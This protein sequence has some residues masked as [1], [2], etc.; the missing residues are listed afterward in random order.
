MM[1]KNNQII[2]FCFCLLWVYPSCTPSQSEKMEEKAEQRNPNVLFIAVDDFNDYMDFWGGHPD[3]V[4]PNIS[5]LAKKS[6]VFLNTYCA[7]PICNPS[8]AALMSGLHPS[9]T[10]VYGNRHPLRLSKRGRNC[11]T[12]TQYFRLQGYK[13][14]GAGK[15]YHNKFPD[16]ASWTDYYPDKGTQAIFKPNGLQ[17]SN[18]PEEGE[19]HQ[20][21]HVR[22]TALDIQDEEM[23]DYQAVDYAIR[24]LQQPHDRP[25]FLACGFNKPHLPWS[26]PQKYFEKFEIE[27]ISTPVFKENDLED[28]PEQG[29]KFTNQDV[30]RKMVEKEKIKEAVQAYLAT[31]NF[32]DA[33]I[34]KVLEALENSAY[35]DNTI[36]VFWSDHGFHL[37]EKLHWRKSTLWEEATRSPM[38]IYLPGKD[39]QVIESPVGLIDLYPTLAALCGLP[40]KKGLDGQSLVPL[41]ENPHASWERP[42]LTTHLRGNHT[43]RTKKWRYIRYYDGTEELY[44]KAQDEMEWHNLAANPAYD[45]VKQ[46]L[47]QW[48][49]EENAP[50]APKV[51]WPDEK[52]KVDSIM[53]EAN[54]EFEQLVNK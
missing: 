3:A 40:E 16:A 22:W 18:V 52:P 29:V 43:L 9:T 44:D 50:N 28:V 13:T 4:T 46:V 10:G 17:V 38:L 30:H 41:I 36:V 45:S 7:A 8:R 42:A 39:A 33:M 19:A 14:M 6:T 23:A 11:V 37:G 53:W 25:F 31:G 34:G 15:M 35:A 49:P 51:Q 20:I 24:Q 1:L 26:V 47:A 5:A 48:L 54:K 21:A 27:N 12:L 2:P 32:V